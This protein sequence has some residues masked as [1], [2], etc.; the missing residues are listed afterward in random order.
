[1][2]IKV[3]ILRRFCSGPRAL[4]APLLVAILFAAG[5]NCHDDRTPQSSDPVDVKIQALAEPQWQPGVFYHLGDLVQFNNIVWECRQDHSGAV[6]FEPPGNYSLWQRPT[7]TDP[8]PTAWAVQVHY[9]VGSDVTYN[10]ALFEC[11][12]EHVAQPGWEP[13]TATAS[14]WRRAST[15]PSACSSLPDGSLCDDGRA[16]NVDR[17]QAGVCV[18]S[19]ATCGGAVVPT[20]TDVG[21]VGGTMSV[22]T[23]GMANYAI[24][25]WT[26]E[27]RNG[28]TPGLALSY[29]SGGSESEV[30]LGWTVAGGLSMIARC[31]SES[32]RDA[33]PRPVSFDNDTYCLDGQRLVPV[34]PTIGTSISEFRTEPDT[35][36]RIT[37]EVKDSLGPIAFTV[38]TQDGSQYSYGPDPV[39]PDANYEIKATRQH[40]FLGDDSRLSAAVKLNRQKLARFGWLRRTMAD[41]SG[42]TITYRYTNS[43][44]QDVNFPQEPRLDS[45]DYVDVSGS[46]SGTAWTRSIK[47]TYGAPPNS[48]QIAS[49]YIS[50][51]QFSR[52]SVLKSIDMQVAPAG[53]LSRKSARFY[54]LTQTTS[55]STNRVLLHTVEECDGDPAPVTGRAGQCKLP[56]TLTYA[57]PPTDTYHERVF[58]DVTDLRQLP[59]SPFWRLHV[60]DLN[61]DGRDDLVYRAHLPN[62]PATDNPH[63]LARLADVDPASGEVTFSAPLDLHL[64]ENTFTG[65]A[66]IADLNHD[67]FPDIAV[68]SGLSTYSYFMNNGGASPSFAPSIFN[69]S[70]TGQTQAIQIADFLGRGHVS[71]LRPPTSGIRWSF[72]FFQSLCDLLPGCSPAPPAMNLGPQ[73][74][75]DLTFD[76][77]GTGTYTSDVDGDGVA[78]LI[79]RDNS[80]SFNNES[81]V[82]HLVA[83]AQDEHGLWNAPVPTTLLASRSDDLINYVFFDHNGD[84][85]AD[86][87][88]LKQNDGQ[89]ALLIN[90]GDSFAAPQMSS[91]LL[92]TI[93]VGAGAVVRD[94]NDTGIRVMDYDGDG[95]DDLLLVDNGAVRDGTLTS[96]SAPRTNFTVLVS[97]QE[98][99]FE[100]RT[101]VSDLNPSGVPIGLHADGATPPLPPLS[102][103]AL[104]HNYRL[105][106]VL[107][108]NGDSLSDLVFVASDG[109]LHVMLRQSDKP[110]LLS[111]VK[112]GMGAKTVINYLPMSDSR[113]YTHPTGE[114]NCLGTR[115]CAPSGDWL[116][117]SYSSDNGHGA[118]QNTTNY[119]YESRVTDTESSQVLGFVSWTVTNAATG[120]ATT[121]TFDYTDPTLVPMSKIGA[122]PTSPDG[123]ASD[124]T[125]KVY[126]LWGLPQTRM[127]TTKVGA[128][129]R[130]VII[131]G[132]VSVDSPSV[133]LY[134][135]VRT[136]GGASYYTRLK[137]AVTH[138]LENGVEISKVVNKPVYDKT[139]DDFG[140][141]SGGKTIT[142]TAAGQF[143]DLWSANYQPD[144]TLWLLALQ[145]NEVDC[146]MT[147]VEVAADIPQDCTIDN[148]KI[149]KR[150]TNFTYEPASNLIHTLDVQPR[151]TADERLHVEYTHVPPFGLVTKVARTDAGGD[152]RADSFTFD[153]RSVHLRTHTNA[154]GQTSTTEIEPALGVLLSET[155]PNNVRTSFDYD[156]FGRVRRINPAG[157]GGTSITYARDLEPNTTLGQDRFVV[158][159]TKVQD[160][161]GE[162]HTLIN[163]VGQPIRSEEK[164]FDGGFAFQSWGYDQLGALTSTTRP[165][166][167]G[168]AEGPKT[169]EVNDELGRLSS[170][171]RPEEAV[172]GSGAPVTSVVL[173][174]AYQGYTG[175][176]TDEVGRVKRHTA[177]PL[178]RIVKTELQNDSGQFIPTD[179]SYGP[180]GLLTNVKRRDAAGLPATGRNTAMAYDSLGRRT[181]LTDPDTGE[182]RFSYNG[183]GDL[184]EQRDAAES[185]TTYTPDALGRVKQKVDKDGTTTFVWDTAD[186]GIGKLA[187]ATSPFGVTRQFFY[188][189]AGRRYREVTTVG[190]VPYQ[191][192]YSFDSVSG[193]VSKV[194][195]PNVP[196]FD[197]LIVANTFEPSSGRLSQVK[198]D[199]TGQAF[200]SLLTT[201][202]DGA[203]IKE[204]FG[205]DVTTTYSHSLTTGRVSGI[206]TTLP[207][208]SK[209]AS[210]WEYAYLGDGNLQRRSD[211]VAKQHERFEYDSLDRIKRW[212]AADSTGNPLAGGWVVKYTMDDF[213]SLSRRQLIAGSATGGTSQD[214]SFTLDPNSSRMTAAPWGAYGYDASGNQ[215]TR[216]DGELV[217]YTAFDLP[218]VTT[219][220]RAVTIDYD[221]FGVRAKKAKSASDYTVYVSGVYEKR[222]SGTVSHPIIDHVFYVNGPFGPTAQVMRREGGSETSKYFHGDRQGSVDAVSEV[223]SGVTKIDSTKR[224]PYGNRVTNFNQP[225]LQFTI[226]GAPGTVRTGFTGHEQDDDLGAVNMLGRLFEPRSA[227]FLTPDP[228]NAR[229]DNGQSFNRY[230]YVMNNPLRRVDP[231]GLATPDGD[232]CVLSNGWPCPG[233]HTRGAV[234]TS[235]GVVY[236]G[237]DGHLHYYDKRTNTD[238]DTT[239]GGNVEIRYKAPKN[240]APATDPSATPHYGASRG[241]TG[242]GGG[243]GGS[244][245]GQGS[246]PKKKKPKADDFKPCGCIGMPGGVPNP[247]D[248]R[249]LEGLMAQFREAHAAYESATSAGARTA[250]AEEAT[251]IA[252]QAV[253]TATRTY[254]IPQGAALGFRYDESVT[255]RARTGR[256]RIVHVGSQAFVGSAGRFGSTLL[257][258]TVHAAQYAAR[259]PPTQEDIAADPG[260]Y[261]RPAIDAQLTPANVQCFGL[262]GPEQGAIKGTF[263][264]EYGEDY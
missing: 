185:V 162:R 103:A 54:R 2:N 192:D 234:S 215:T 37:V 202:I 87:I 262:T 188:D 207:G 129:T 168:T 187:S 68:P 245:K 218:H 210:S 171:T 126:S 163:R 134:E 47:F 149:P 176:T 101:V 182:R 120:A 93:A 132:S 135:F 254:G 140:L 174:V 209:P 204:T 53:S 81:L 144:T 247:S 233:S 23:S 133:I 259:N 250:F 230:A 231:A 130:K 51:V 25:L 237:S 228:V 45:I 221:A 94:M 50:G 205:D 90:N 48:S 181:L 198:N 44:T 12:T 31:A 260:K 141:V 180:F 83:L 191:V 109:K 111:N 11:I 69:E 169:V 22:S 216:P 64:E 167:L 61:G 225:S 139:L 4:R 116:V 146:S 199:S 46:G 78:D 52:S 79:A 110:D 80:G 102:G 195:Y 224:D 27:G 240:S 24:P 235:E 208:A 155:D 165:A 77:D 159:T 9:A 17:C 35:F 18:G 71:I 75:S 66:V 86:A 242:G 92:H 255:D 32:R 219:G 96:N 21:T 56:T 190:G 74:L 217:T 115:N 73:V 118:E 1:M 10:G 121:E 20:A 76:T 178:G 241:G 138:T 161:G 206:S 97:R 131:D 154:L 16:C 158:K 60:A 194:S 179:Y 253:G 264:G 147:P 38:K 252:N 153:D 263:K 108:V 170:V 211:L 166:K 238:T 136:N 3:D 91:S 88:R 70:G 106:Q 227:R 40:W 128:T 201:E 19:A 98:G 212:L 229:P 99:T 256:D 113:V 258:E 36:S 226:S 117:S 119:H 72:H 124:D 172:N 196:G 85:L 63:W 7:P 8:G 203:V 127:T 30:G 14:L 150:V 100:R 189:S 248:V 5:I 223:V 26:P 105:T 15:G 123:G 6:G 142:S 33:R 29:A 186:N 160:G 125:A 13:G 214:V 251:A 156:F 107:D 65:D 261:Q 257:H 243:T 67:G 193:N 213:G 246:A 84:G 28:M 151:G 177:D 236:E 49:S 173:G 200:W 89:P 62:A 112:D 183:F 55:P 249:E 184:R 152:T 58:P 34:A 137:R 42:N 157:G 82:N 95:K 244:A 239:D 59:D 197:R 220:P 175:T 43:G 143:I 114:L 145:Q 41:R 104:V 122:P 39:T 57:T 164:T 222:V 148:A 232:Q